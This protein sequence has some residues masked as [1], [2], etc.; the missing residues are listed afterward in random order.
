VSDGLTISGGGSYAVASD[1]LFTDAQALESVRDDLRWAAGA[2]ARIDALVAER[3]LHGADVP[4]SALD[5]EREIDR[6][7]SLLGG[8]DDRAG[9]LAF[10]LRASAEAYGRADAAAQRVAQDLAASLGYSLGLMIPMVA[11]VAAPAL[12]PLLAGLLV[13]SLVFPGG[14]KAAG[15]A[16]GSW[17]GSNN[18]VLTNPVAVALI[19]TGVMSIDDVVG[20]AIGVPPGIVRLL[21][22]EGLALAGVASSAGAVTALGPRAGLFAETAVATRARVHRD[23]GP[24][25]A[26][27]AERLDRIPQRVTTADGEPAGQ[28]IR[29]EKYS[30]P[31]RPD[32]FE[33]YITGTADFS[34]Q[35]G[36]DPFDLTSDVGTMAGLPAGAVRAV[37]Q[38]MRQEGV[39]ATS[40]VQFTGYSQGGL[41]AATLGASG[42]YNTHGV[43]AIGSPTGQIAV[44]G[45]YPAVLL[46]HT[47]DLVPALGGNRVSHDAV[48]VEREA[49]A[50]RATPDGVA[51]P[52]HD[53]SEYRHTA[54][55]A[56]AA[57]SAQLTRAIDRIDGFA[58]G[59]TAESATSYV[60]ERVR[61]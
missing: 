6:A 34:P 49:F 10:V 13:G 48:L 23:G 1:A 54:Q 32:R 9:A 47:D 29:I 7:R 17:L 16:V 39:T 59:M 36:A 40:P 28:H 55:L 2:L 58:D 19:R 37:E 12:P 3:T 30:A 15:D 5:A 56:D 33:V 31:G 11:V 51:V 52:A 53:R 18:R 21:G 26:G 42:D 61:K 25:P 8:L 22:D 27:L 4:A 41:I 43:V 24:P 45:D 35:T 50:G 60:A 57:G 14:L 46:E 20:G 38:A 44:G